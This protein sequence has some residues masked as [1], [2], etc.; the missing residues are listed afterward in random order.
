VTA[1]NAAGLTSSTQVYAVRVDS[2][3]PSPVAWAAAFSAARA[4][5]QPSFVLDWTGG[6]D[7][8]SGLATGQWVQ[9]YRAPLNSQGMCRV[10]AFKRDGDGGLRTDGAVDAGLT[11]GAC[12][13]WSVRTL[14]NVGNAAPPVWSDTLVAEAL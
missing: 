6:S 7:A 12:Y 14:D 9:R 11:A 10:S 5:A 1:R 8:G 2:E 13:R 4:P 3:A